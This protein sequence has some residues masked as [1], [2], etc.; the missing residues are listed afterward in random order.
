MSWFRDMPIRLAAALVAVLLSQA[1]AL[2]QA[3]TVGRPDEP[4]MR[5]MM[6][7]MQGMQACMAGLDPSALERLQRQAEQAESEL[8]ALCRAGQAAAAQARALDLGRQISADPS[9][10]TMT[11]CL[12]RL[13]KLPGMEA[14]RGRFSV[15]DEELGD[16]TRPVCERLN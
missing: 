7:A 14:P 3:D 5:Q 11:A 1:Q 6:E 8:R 4:D 12:A 2:A 15:A 10:K 16:D 9:V 13:P